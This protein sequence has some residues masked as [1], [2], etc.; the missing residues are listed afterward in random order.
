[1]LRWAFVCLVLAVAAGLAGFLGIANS[2][3][4]V[5]KILFLAFLVGAAL[6]F[7]AG[8]RKKVD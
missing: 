4:E 5:A 1:M 6:S 3:G 2:F 7:F 8:I